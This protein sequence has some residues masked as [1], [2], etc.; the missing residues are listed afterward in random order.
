MKTYFLFILLVL[1]F[2]SVSLLGQPQLKE[3]SFSFDYVSINFTTQDGL[4]SNEVYSVFQDSKGYIWVG[5]D[6]GV[7]KYDGYSFTT[8][9]T[10]NG[11]T[12]NTIFDIAEDSQGRIW[13]TTSNQTLCY[14]DSIGRI[15]PYNYNSD[16]KRI[17]DKKTRG[18]NVFFDQI[19][20][21]D[22]DHLYLSHYKLGYIE[23]PLNKPGV[24]L[25]FIKDLWKDHGV[26]I[27]H[28]PQYQNIMVSSFKRQNQANYKYLNNQIIDTVSLNEC[29]NS[30][31]PYVLNDSMYYY[32]NKIYVVN[33][34]N[35]V[36]KQSFPY[37]I[38]AFRAG[39]V[40]LL[41]KLD[42]NKSYGE[43]F[44]VDELLD[45]PKW[46]KLFHKKIRLT[47]SCRDR[48]D[49]LWLGSVENG[50]FYLP[51]SDNKLVT[52][53]FNTKVILPYGNTV[54]LAERDQKYYSYHSGDSFLEIGNKLLLDS[55]FTDNK[56]SIKL[57]HPIQIPEVT[58]WIKKNKPFS[59]FLINAIE[60]DSN[61]IRFSS[62]TKLMEYT[63]ENGIETQ[64]HQHSLGVIYCFEQ[65]DANTLILGHLNGLA[66]TTGD[67]I[68][69]Y[70][71]SNSNFSWK[72]KDLKVFKRHKIIAVATTG[73]G[74]FIFKDGELLK[75]L[76]VED[77]L[78]SN[79][80]NQLVLDNSDRLWIGTNKGINYLDVRSDMTF[81]IGS[82]FSS[83]KSL[84]SPNVQQIHVINDSLLIIGTDKGV[85]E[86][87]IK[88]FERR[89]ILPTPIYLTSVLV[90]DSI[91][92]GHQ[93]QYDQNNI[94]FEYTA[95]EYNQ[96]GDLSYR[97][98]LNGQFSNWIY[99]KHRQ[100][101]FMQV[102]PGNYTFEL[103]VQNEFG[104]WISLEQ[105]PAFTIGKPYWKTWWFI[106]SSILMSLFIIGSIL[107][108]YISNLQEVLF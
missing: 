73:N 25:D 84:S 13:F 86:I 106:G 52:S 41:N 53:N 16:I 103:E 50:V 77:G 55:L 105:P 61:R 78:V 19:F 20:I 72:A 96:F 85:N 65:L 38:H 47:Y 90:N 7:S 27:T 91:E 71:D 74:L 31:R 54:L 79:S 45:E 69:N 98:R 22:N 49:G 14:L 97:Y 48:N 35:L 26:Y 68:Q 21:D 83:S 76:T 10:Q 32:A 60:L 29:F 51:N 64:I 108:Y 9:T 30:E 8:L 58:Q 75:Q 107:Y 2:V 44:L 87:N 82:L 81:K 67:T 70:L 12:D 46:E 1:G 92:F 4:P 43:V 94:V 99:T 37:R 17:V 42:S 28:S 63:K 6:R 88:A 36:K 23:V 56:T 80:I 57:S 93:L 62:G 59:S 100:A 40:L 89:E 24:I 66:L 5:T 18:E 101:T 104:D 39:N 33:K 102:L 11:L 95:L 3:H 34:Q 15:M